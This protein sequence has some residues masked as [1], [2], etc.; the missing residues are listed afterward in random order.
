MD[1]NVMLFNDFETLD[2][3]GP[4]EIM[5]RLMDS[6]NIRFFSMTGGIIRSKQGV[7]VVSESFESIDPKGILFIPGGFGTRTLVEDE[8]YIK[9]IKELDKSSTYTLTVCTGTAL[10]AKTGHLKGK[11][12]TTNKIAFDWVSSQ[13]R[14]VLWQKS[15]RWC[16]DGKY[17][18]SSGVS[19]GM[20]MTLGFV[21][22]T[23]S[24][25]EA[26]KISNHIEY[27]WNEDMNNDPFSV[28]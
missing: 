6:Y 10:L 27:I 23:H 21:S 7:L 28:E 2:V 18:T 19:A 12:A 4:V 13:D 20:D 5:G 26:L 15:A 1:V 16:V 8:E 22:D 25:E 11:I 24:R 9:T 17:Y 3:F 14:D